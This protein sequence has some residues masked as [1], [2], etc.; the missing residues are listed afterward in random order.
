MLSGA[1]FLP[2][3]STFPK[4]RAQYIVEDSGCDTILST[5]DYSTQ[6]DW[7]TGSVVLFDDIPDLAVDDKSMDHMINRVATSDLAYAIY[8]SGTTGKPKGVEV[9]HLG[10]LNMLAHHKAETLTQ[11]QIQKCV[12]VASFIFD[13]SIR[14]MFLP[15]TSGT[16]LCI[17][18][19]AL[20]ITYGTCTGG[21]P[22]A[23]A[24]ALMPTMMK[25]ALIGGERL[26]VA[27]VKHLKALQTIV[28]VYG[29]TETTVECTTHVADPAK[30]DEIALIGLPIRNI[31][32]YA[33]D[34]DS[35]K[36]VDRG[37]QGELWISGPGVA[38]G[39]RNRPDLN[40]DK[41]I[42][43]PWKQGERVFATGDLVKWAAT[44]DIEF[45]G[46]ADSQVKIRGYRIELEEIER[47]CSEAP[48]VM[49]A[50]VIVAK[51]L[52]GVEQ[53]V[54]Y[55]EPC[56]EESVVTE[57]C[58]SKLAPYMLP[59]QVMLMETFPL[60]T[61]GKIDKGQLPEVVWHVPLV[62]DDALVEAATPM[63]RALCNLIENIF[64][65]KCSAD[66]DFFTD[67]GLTSLDCA[68]L[69][70]ES[71]V[72][73]IQIRGTGVCLA[74]ST[75]QKLAA[76]LVKDQNG[77]EVEKRVRRCMAFEPHDEICA[78]ELVRLTTAPLA[79]STQWI[80]FAV[81]FV[82]N[83]TLCF[84]PPAALAT[85]ILCET[86]RLGRTDPNW[87]VRLSAGNLDPGLVAT[88]WTIPVLFLVLTPLILLWG[89]LMKWLIIGKYRPGLHAV[90]GCYYIRWW[91]AH[92]FLTFNNVFILPMFRNT[93]VINWYFRMLGMKI[94]K[95]TLIDTTHIL[96]PDLISLG[97]NCRLQS[98]CL[99]NAHVLRWVQET[100]SQILCLGKIEID[101]NL[102]VGPSATV[103][104][105][106]ASSDVHVRNNLPALTSAQML[107][108]DYADFADQVL[109]QPPIGVVWQVL[110]MLLSLVL[111][112][113]SV[114]V[115]VL[116]FYQVFLNG[117]TTQQNGYQ[118]T[119]GFFVLWW[120]NF[121]WLAGLPYILLVGV[122][123]WTVIFKFREGPSSDVIDVKRFLLQM[124]VQSRLLANTVFLGASSHIISLY[125][126][127]MG[128]HIGWNTQ[129]MPC[130]LVEFD[131][132]W[133]GESVAFGGFVSCFHAT[134]TATCPASQLETILL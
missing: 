57:F 24:V 32:A 102:I 108:D 85:L 55:V 40:K 31:S 88:F 15:L 132:L 101:D 99:V 128:A 110:G 53:I 80:V 126:R 86:H 12:I 94:G 21:T 48:G 16:C 72:I 62:A 4:D 81:G 112:W 8:T 129:V 29:P 61:S 54:V 134:R 49:N 114:M 42:P 36:L 28:N 84:W 66:A 25:A 78:D 43:N 93:F 35:N 120:V 90:G 82:L 39:Y 10:V 1:A 100:Q 50:C 87:Q 127:F 60:T 113:I 30:E 17:A 121:Y 107:P 131:L 23:L 46:R 44:G 74:N 20:N 124:L 103:V 89:I 76:H 92:G 123:K 125:F 91:M 41:F 7:F 119:H 13:S 59:A 19:N 104:V 47:V 116:V 98:D 6:L 64:Q 117:I 63:E 73:G 5:Q 11:D 22:S 38:R 37:C 68:A 52:R 58:E 34:K 109:W 122:F 115:P 2:I 96:E 65:L 18:E 75:V 67:L 111:H 130:T 83:T 27:C 51:D 3:S 105:K 70:A 118:A 97:K 79:R 45:L 69:V 71:V 9:E 95:G 106:D 33:V 56:V 26:T 133:I 77:I 14:E